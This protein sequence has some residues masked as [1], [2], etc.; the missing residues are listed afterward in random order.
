MIH[1]GRAGIVAI[2]ATIRADNVSGIAYYEKIGFRIYDVRQGVPL[3]AGAPWA[4]FMKAACLGIL[5][6]PIS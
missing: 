1:A 4:N 6:V 2:N 3:Q 5:P